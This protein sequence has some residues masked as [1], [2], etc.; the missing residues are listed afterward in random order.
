MKKVI[1]LELEESEY[2]A[3]QRELNN[4]V[5]IRKN[6][7]EKAKDA[8]LLYDP[9]WMDRFA[10]LQSGLRKFESSWKQGH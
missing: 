10:P 3:M 4:F 1:R 8:A 9:G 7:Y 5:G 6:E 2:D